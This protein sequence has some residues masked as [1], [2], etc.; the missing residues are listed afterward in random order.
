MSHEVLKLGRVTKVKVLFLLLGLVFN[1]NLFK[2]P[3]TIL[4]KGLL[5][6]LLRIPSLFHPPFLIPDF[7]HPSWSAPVMQATQYW[8]CSLCTCIIWNT[9]WHPSIGTS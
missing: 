4:E 2:F 6:L 9:T 7:P 1:F 5:G 8:I 3:A